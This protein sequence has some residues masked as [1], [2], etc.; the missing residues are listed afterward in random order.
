MRP[1][2]LAEH[3]HERSSV[4]HAVRFD[5]PHNEIDAMKEREQ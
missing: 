2:S 3:E 1:M 4:R 5:E